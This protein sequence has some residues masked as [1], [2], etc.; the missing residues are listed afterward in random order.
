MKRF[1]LATILCLA[2]APGW[3]QI[4][5]ESLRTLEGHPGGTFAVA[6]SPDGRHVVSGGADKTLRL[7]ETNSGRL[8]RNFEGHEG[9]V[10]SVVLSADGRHALS[11]SADGSV[12][13]WE[14][15]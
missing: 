11:G 15:A 5:D 8:V 6:F 14:V 3:A 12:R 9:R 2:A 7:W 13:L 1:I 4:A 10:V